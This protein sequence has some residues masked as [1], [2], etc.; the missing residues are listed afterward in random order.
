MSQVTYL[1]SNHEIVGILNRL[2]NTDDQ[3]VMEFTIHKKIGIP[4][5]AIPIEELESVVGNRV[6]VFNCSGVY[7]LRK[8]N[9]K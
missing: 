2:E 9:K 6:G 8:A 7:K 4:R 1:G 5:G 3:I